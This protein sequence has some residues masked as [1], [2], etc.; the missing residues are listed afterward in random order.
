MK[1]SFLELGVGKGNQFWKYLIV[2]VLA[3][4]VGKGLG[5]I[6]LGVVVGL[7]RVQSCGDSTYD[8]SNIL[9]F[10]AMGISLNLGLFLV[11]LMFAVGLFVFIGLVKLF[12]NGRTYKETING[13]K[14][15]RWNRV[16]VGVIGWGVIMTILSAIGLILNPENYV[17]QFDI[18]KFI[19]LIF[20]ALLLIPLQTTF[21]EL[22]L[23]GYFAQGLAGLTGSRWV[24]FL[25]PSIVFG[26]MHA[27]NPEV[28]EFGFW[29]MMPQYII[30]GLVWGLISTLDDGIEIAI[31]AHAINNVFI[32]LFFTF[33][34]SV[35]QTYALFEIQEINPV[36]SLIS[37][38]V[39]ST[40]FVY[41]LHRKY[42]WD[43]S[44]LNKRVEK[45]E[46][47]EEEEIANVSEQANEYQQ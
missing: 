15:I 29:L 35:L 45:Q 25:I 23:R 41:I 12:H 34:A 22:T 40:I 33:H 32:C 19:P 24:A 7:R 21:E 1:M 4:I 5:M 46:K 28:A 9:D 43:F 42:K 2:I 17:F 16:W 30:S 20:I 37:L 39:A 36:A 11:M 38:I 31:G 10:S 13:T 8:F 6:P 47:Q 27:G 3:W 14:K 44:I 26:L 18:T